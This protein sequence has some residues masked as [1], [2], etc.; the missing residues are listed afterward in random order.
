MG[1]CFRVNK[2][3]SRDL[4]DARIFL[5]S[6]KQKESVVLACVPSRDYN[7]VY[8]SHDKSRIIMLPGNT[9]AFYFPFLDQFE[10]FP[11]T[12]RLGHVI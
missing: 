5:S 9:S 1:S 11:I 10:T 6:C 3:N 8:F 4:P 2:R 7:S 12:N